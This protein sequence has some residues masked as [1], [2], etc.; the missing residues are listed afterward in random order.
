M[1]GIALLG[2]RGHTGRELIA[3]I[4]GHPRFELALAAARQA[5]GEPVA[6]SVPEYRG[7]LRFCSFDEAELFAAP[8]AAWVLALPNGEAAAWAARIAAHDPAAVILD[9]SADH[10]LDPAWIYG[11]PE[12]HRAAL[13][14]ARR[15]ANPGC[16][17]TAA[18]LALWP[19]RDRL[20]GVPRL[21]GV[22]G[23]SGA[24]STPSPRNDPARLADNVLPYQLTGHLHQLE[25]GRELGREVVLMPH[26]APFFR[27][28]VVTASIELTA[29]APA[30]PQEIYRACYGAEPLIAITA[31]PAEPASMAGSRGAVIGGASVDPRDRRRLAVTVALDNLL[32]GAASQAI[33]NLNL[34]LGVD[35][36]V[37]VLP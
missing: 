2:A 11:L 12:H 21:F 27:G 23:Y 17:A 30:E 6:A 29:K 32:K 15:I 8:V 14:G 18:L 9:L 24:G 28:L 3:L 5:A 1:S 25:V 4:A 35:E 37:G 13:A 34:A 22:S 33:Q 7:D 26:V 10:R 19:W 20:A 36:W 16:Y 31:E